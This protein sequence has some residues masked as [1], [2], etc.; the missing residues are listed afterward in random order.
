MLYRKVLY[1]LNGKGMKLNQG[2]TMDA[3]Y[4][5]PISTITVAD[6]ANFPYGN[7]EDPTLVGLVI[8]DQDATVRFKEKVRIASEI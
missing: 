1:N 6:A 4:P 2:L 7:T 3:N 5:G 8:S